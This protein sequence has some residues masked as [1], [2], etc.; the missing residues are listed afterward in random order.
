[1]KVLY[2]LAKICGTISAMII[3]LFSIIG[4]ALSIKERNADLFI[5]GYVVYCVGLLMIAAVWSK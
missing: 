1:M 3:L 5:Y 4:I 2:A